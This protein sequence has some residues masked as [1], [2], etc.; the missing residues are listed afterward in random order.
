MIT[1]NLKRNSK[2]DNKIQ[3]KEYPKNIKNTR[4]NFGRNSRQGR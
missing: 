2:T 4:S 3:S 1:K